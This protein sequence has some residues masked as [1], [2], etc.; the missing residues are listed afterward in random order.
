M[1]ETLETR[2][3]SAILIGAGNR[4]LTAYGRYAENNPE[5]L[6][7]IAVAD[8]NA[9]KRKLFQ[10]LHG[11]Q[12]ELCFESWEDMLNKDVG[13]IA[14]VCFVCTPDRSHY[15]P[16]IRALEM[17]YN[18]LLEKPIAPELEQC[19]HIEKLAKEKNRLV[20]V[21]H[22]LRF[23]G[24][25]KKVKEIIDSGEIGN[26]LH[27]EHSENVSHWHYGHSYVR[28]WYKNEKDS[29]PFIMAKSC[30]DLDLIHW[31]IGDYPEEVVSTGDLTFYKPENAP[32]GAPDRCTDGCPHSETCSW[33]APRMYL[34]LEPIIRVP[35]NK[36]ENSLGIF[37]LASKIVFRLTKRKKLITFLSKIIPP[38]R[39]FL[40]WDRFPVSAITD[41]FSIEGRMKA[42]REGQFGLC[43]FKAGNDVMDHHVS[44]YVFPNGII[45]T[46]LVYGYSD[47]EGR[48]LRIMGTKGVLRGIFR[49]FKQEI[50]VTD[51]RTNKT[52]KRFKLGLTASGHGGGDTG[53][54]SA[55]TAY[56]LGEKTKEEAGLTDI[57][58][59]MESHYMGF[60]AE[61]ARIN[62]KMVELK[63]LRP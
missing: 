16:A 25:F 28:G 11:I 57:S 35:T 34:D 29:S 41:D 44:T 14:D 6:K 56:L 61:K 2:L 60:A 30:H 38:I 7:F 10:E 42:L 39:K 26:I 53:I 18:L 46:L 40:E 17:E 15:K 43:I 63:N 58:S 8:P 51:F 20:Q 23:T 45:G 9:E 22:V 31:I 50:I 48:E 1:G 32:P 59:A 62:R 47:W 36:N 12:P 54:M 3:V 4:G 52:K 33:Y 5:K 24:F 19:Q 37:R 55:F 27:Y 13:K 21:G 49:S